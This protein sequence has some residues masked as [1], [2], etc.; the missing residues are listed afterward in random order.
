M[1]KR[2]MNFRLGEQAREALASLT[3]DW[4]CSGAAVVERVL[5]DAARKDP[6]PAVERAGPPTPRSGGPAETVVDK[7]Q[8]AGLRQERGKFRQ[9]I[10]KPK[11]RGLV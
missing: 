2:L 3:V 11:D 7:G 10:P 8:R 5:I 1:A 4:G 6:E 9:R